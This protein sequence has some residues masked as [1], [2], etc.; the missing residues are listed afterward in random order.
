MREPVRVEKRIQIDFVVEDV[1]CFA[2]A[3]WLLKFPR[4]PRNDSSL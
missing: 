3:D 1:M 2:C 4:F